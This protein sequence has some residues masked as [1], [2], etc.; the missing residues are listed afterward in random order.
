MLNILLNN[1]STSDRKKMKLGADHPS[2]VVKAALPH[3]A[4]VW[5]GRRF[6]SADHGNKT[7]FTADATTNSVKVQGLV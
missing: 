1:S 5:W 2:A 4:W 3:I 6:N 7:N